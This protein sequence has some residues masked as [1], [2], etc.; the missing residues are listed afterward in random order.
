MKKVAFL[1]ASAVV[2][3][4]A[5]TSGAMK[6]GPDTYMITAQAETA[7][8]RSGK[9]NE[10]ALGKAH[11]HCAGLGKEVLVTN[12]FHRQSPFFTTDITFQCLDAGDPDLK[13]PVY[14]QAPD[15]L[16]ESR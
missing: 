13:R 11:S 1:V 7:G 3:G 14:T 9:V 5:T 15:I 2:A 4:C 8:T 6:L 10:L 12:L 16:I